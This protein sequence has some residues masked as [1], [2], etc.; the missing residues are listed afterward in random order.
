MKNLG[1][2][3]SIRKNECIGI[4][5]RA[6]FTKIKNYARIDHKEKETM[7]TIRRA[8]LTDIPRLNELLQEILQVHHVARPDLFSASGQKFSQDELAILLKN[9]VKPVFVYED[10][11]QVLGHL[12]CEIIQ[13]DSPVLEPVKTLFIDDL[14]VTSAARGQKIGEKLYDFAVDYAKEI[15]CHN[16]TLDVWNDN[17]GALRFYERLGMKPQKTRMEIRL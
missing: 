14:C 7:M 11:G 17:Q 15:G 1:Y 12:F 13:L 3:Y 16:I 9:E 6:D 4:G 10:E 8:T 2:S 5:L